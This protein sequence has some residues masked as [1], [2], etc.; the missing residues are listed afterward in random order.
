M[1]REDR[2]YGWCFVEWCVA[3]LFLVVAVLARCPRGR[4]AYLPVG[5]VVPSYPALQ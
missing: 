1:L 2:D 4:C 5:A 3:F